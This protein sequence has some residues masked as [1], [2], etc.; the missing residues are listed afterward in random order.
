VSVQIPTAPKRDGLT[1]TQFL[2]RRTVTRP[3]IS[4]LI[5]HERKTVL[6]LQPEIPTVT[7]SARSEGLQFVRL[8]ATPAHRLPPQK[9]CRG[10]H[11]SRAMSG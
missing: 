1:R 11:I 5:W 6:L 10:P 2:R 8:S 4:S 7:L 9:A 3:Q